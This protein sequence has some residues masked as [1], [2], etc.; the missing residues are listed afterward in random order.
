MPKLLMFTTLTLWSM[1]KGHG[2]PAFTQTVKKYIDAGWEV[3]LISDEPSNKDYPHLDRE[4]NLFLKPFCFKKWGNARKI[5]FVFRWLD[6]IL[7]NARFV[8]LGKKMLSKDCGDTVLYAYEIFAVRACSRLSKKFSLPVVTRFQGTILSQYQNTFSNRLARYPHYSA[9]AQP[10]DLVIMTDDGT[11]GNQVLQDLKNTS[12][13]LFLRNGLEL[14]E[15]DI[16]AMKDQFDRTSFRKKLGAKNEDTV[17]LTVSRLADWKRVDRAITGFAAFC[18]SGLPGRLVIVGDGNAKP[19]LEQQAKDLGVADR[20]VFT[21][22]VSHAEVYDYMM[23]CDVFMSL[24]DL[25]NVGNP[26]LEAMA[27]GKCIITLDVGDTGKLITNR[28]NG[29]LL[30]AETLPA[31]GDIMTEL[32]ENIS[33]RQALSAAAESY[34]QNHFQTWQSRMETEFQAVAALLSR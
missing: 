27:L 25:S 2:G 28:Q 33:L 26:L 3:Y 1:G 14:M 17:F 22:S 9:L 29:I 20:V 32:S 16:T 19:A 8:R 11:Q 4:H 15:K 5:G 21:G 34:A 12:R 6:H 30:S 10:S 23:A 31:L 7:M 18:K 24:Y 13:T